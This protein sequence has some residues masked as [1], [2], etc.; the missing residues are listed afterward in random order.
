MIVKTTS[1]D[2]NL[3]FLTVIR[4][5]KCTL[6]LLNENKQTNKLMTHLLLAS[7]KHF[8]PEFH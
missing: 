2:Y 1:T 7:G 3:H 8:R 4:A 6:S 5:L